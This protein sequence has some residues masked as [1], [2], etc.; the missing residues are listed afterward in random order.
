MLVRIL[1][2]QPRQMR[3]FYHFQLL[4]E[5]FSV[6]VVLMVVVLM[7]VVLMVVVFGPRVFLAK[8]SLPHKYS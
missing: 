8:S 2:H 6:V 4:R 1:L 7:V 3:H 5:M